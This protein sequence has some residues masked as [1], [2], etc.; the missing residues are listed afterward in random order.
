MLDCPTLQR[1][2]PTSAWWSLSVTILISS[3]N[4]EGCQ[5]LT[6]VISAKTFCA[7]GWESGLLAA[8]VLG[9]HF[10]PRRNMWIF[11]VSRARRLEKR[12]K[13]AKNANST[14]KLQHFGFR[15]LSAPK[16]PLELWRANNELAE[17]LDLKC[18]RSI[19]SSF[20]TV[21]IRLLYISRCHHLPCT[22][23]C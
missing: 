8:V 14:N 20:S 16:P 12:N 9:N 22:S 10:E 17:T 23:I 7:G 2:L 21:A 1:L 3:A 19:E 11:V 6:V 18:R 13:G 4:R 5:T 15:S